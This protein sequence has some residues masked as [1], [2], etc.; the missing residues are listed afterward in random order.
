MSEAGP[1]VGLGEGEEVV[2]EEGDD[3][4]EEGDSEEEEEESAVLL[5]AA[6]TASLSNSEHATVEE[7]HEVLERVGQDPSQL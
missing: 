4:V 1:G 6:Q 7:Q 3:E 2:D 5:L